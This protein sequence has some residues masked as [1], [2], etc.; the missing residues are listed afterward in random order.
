[1]EPPPARSAAERKR[2]VL[3]RLAGD[4][5]L[6]LATASAEGGVHLVPLSFVW[7][8]E[9]IVLVTTATSRTV[10][11]LRAVPRARAAL[12]LVRDVVL[13]EGEATITALGGP[14]AAAV[15]AFA[16]HTGWDPSGEPDQ[17]VV[18]LRP[19]R[20]LAWREANELPGRTLMRAGAWLV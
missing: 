13:V 6:W 8:D 9:R 19:E 4:I 17:V 5:D 3:G 7:H 15:A 1:M 14:T 11:N 12:G 16:A 2:D 20:I 10:T 18:E